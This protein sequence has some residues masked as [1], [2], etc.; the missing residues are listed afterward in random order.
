M[1]GRTISHYRITEKLGQ[2]GMGVVYKAEDLHLGRPA[3]LKFL[4]PAY[5]EDEEQRARFIKEARAAAALDHPNICTI[6]EAGE[7]DGLIFLAMAYVE[8]DT[9]T[10]KI[11]SGPLDEAQAVDIAVQIADG[12]QEAHQNDIVHRDIKSSNIMV[13]SKGQVKI[14]DFG[15]AKDLA[16]ADSDQTRQ[17]L[18]TPAYMSPEQT[19]E[20]RVDQR[21]DIWSLGVVLYQMLS[22]KLPF[23]GKFDA[24]IVY[25]VLLHEEP[26]PLDDV[27][28]DVVPGVDAV[29]RCALSKSRRRRY[30]AV[31]E[32]SGALRQLGLGPAPVTQARETVPPPARPLPRA[33]L[34]TGA[35]LIAAALAA[36]FIPWRTETPAPVIE[37]VQ[38]AERHGLA[39][40]PL[41]NLSGLESED[42]FAYGMTEQLTTT[43]AKI[44]GLR[45]ISQG[46]IVGYKD[47]NASPSEIARDLNISYLVE[48]SVQRERDRVRITAQLIEVSSGELI[49]TRN[50]DRDLRDVFKLQSEVARSIASQIRVRLT[51]AEELRLSRTR[52]ISP[53]AYEQY[54]KGRFFA[55]S[56]T[57]EGL[58][59]SLEHYR[60]VLVESPEAALAHAGMADTLLLQANHGFVPPAQVWPKAK[61]AAEKALSLDPELA[62]AHSTLGLI[63]SRFEW[64][65]EVAENSYLRALELYPGDATANLR[66]STYLSRMERHEEAIEAIRR[67]RDLD[68]LSLT[69]S[70]AVGVVLHMARR[71]GEAIE[72][73]RRNLEL[74]ESYYRTFYNLGRSYRELSEYDKAVAALDQARAMSGD[75]P[76]LAAALGHAYG[77]AGETRQAERLLEDVASRADSQ[78][79]SPA[80]LALL[81]LGLEDFDA[82]FLQLDRAVEERAALLT[83]LRVDPIFDPIRERPRFAEL[84]QKVGLD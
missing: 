78:Y 16:S 5:L 80:S 45:V 18:G 39:V 27:A 84:L 35:A 61:A 9:V 43:L 57:Q 28:P 30:Q 3:A 72:Q 19:R 69:I 15:I 40:M 36:W 2:G 65:W 41:T 54:L 55:N 22:G 33:R 59:R 66:Y 50:Y 71:H 58:A 12:L 8:G 31:S 14:L 24:A 51:P 79:V 38:P 34:A 47:R 52:P 7:E 62:E 76:F 67:A 44:E 13:T 21:S 46:S 53:D 68:P 74:P 20:E 81:Y 11:R 37:N 77:R 25:A 73:F 64:N 60:A 10:Q 48:G 6:Y 1:I 17:V 56:R 75:R 23:A 70:N 83:W 29:V 82:A 4:S 42:Y 26:V 63:L 32:M 49:W